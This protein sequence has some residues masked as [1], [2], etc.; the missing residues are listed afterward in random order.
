MPNWSRSPGSAVAGQPSLVF[1]Q[2]VRSRSPPRA[3]MELPAQQQSSRITL[4]CSR[5]LIL[6]GNRGWSPK[7]ATRLGGVVWPDFQMPPG[8][9]KDGSANFSIGRGNRCTGNAARRASAAAWQNC[10][11]RNS[12]LTSAWGFESN[13]QSTHAGA[14]RTGLRRRAQSRD[15][16]SRRPWARGPF[17]RAC[18]RPRAKTG[19]CHPDHW[20]GAAGSSRARQR[21]QSPW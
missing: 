4:H 17:A 8:C 3:E 15:R 20:P 1:P 19:G 6:V 13:Q 9:F 18:R 2:T 11:H 10:A 5:L 14:S 21:R 12:R 7:R 16:I